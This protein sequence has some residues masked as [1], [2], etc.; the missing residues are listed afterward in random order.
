MAGQ[1]TCG[2]RITYVVSQGS[3]RQAAEDKIGRDF[4]SECGACRSGGGAP[5]PTPP[6]PTPPGGTLTSSDKIGINFSVGLMNN[7]LDLSLASS[8]VRQL[9]ITKV[10]LFTCDWPTVDALIDDYVANG[11]PSLQI[12]IDVPNHLVKSRRSSSERFGAA[13]ANAI[14]TKISQSTAAGNP[15]RNHISFVMIGN[16]PLADWNQAGSGMRGATVRGSAMGFLEAA[17]RRMHTAL[18][19]R[20]LTSVK[21]TVPFMFACIHDSY[22]ASAGRI[23]TKCEADMRAI[24]GFLRETGSSFSM[25]LYT[26]HSRVS[27]P[28]QISIAYATGR[29]GSRY[30]ATENYLHLLDAM[31]LATRA[32]VDRAGFNDVPIIVGESGWPTGGH[33][34]ATV[35]NAQAYTASVIAYPARA[36]AEGRAAPSAVYLFEAFDEERKSNSVE[37]SAGG[38]SAEAHYGLLASSGAQK[39]GYALSFLESD[40]QW[41]E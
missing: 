27:N 31:F 19:A 3:T 33:A 39:P 23:A 2:A 13:D 18:T 26:Y 17:C 41:I 9:G 15:R 20:G 1:Y 35:A 36:A 38:G 37:A 7:P 32:A 30:S 10:K 6:A 34:D 4:P 25:N 29:S 21:V 40:D 22:P 24:L 5:A 14:A 11:V 12:V 8:K 16:E 28:G